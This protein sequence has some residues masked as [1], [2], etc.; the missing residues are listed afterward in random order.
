MLDFR[1]DA[2]KL[3]IVMLSIKLYVKDLCGKFDLSEENEQASACPSTDCLALPKDIYIDL[4]IPTTF[5]LL[6]YP[7]Q[8][9]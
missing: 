4:S 8:C 7:P 2:K 5:L 1:A 9:M 6:R 3:M